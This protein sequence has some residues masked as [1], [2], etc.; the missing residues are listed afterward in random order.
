MTI[1]AQAYYEN[2]RFGVNMATVRHNAYG[3]SFCDGYSDPWSLSS[4]KVAMDMFHEF[5]ADKVCAFQP[6]AW[7]GEKSYSICKSDMIRQDGF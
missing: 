1:I 2:G 5:L 7:M 4:E 6:K 3:F